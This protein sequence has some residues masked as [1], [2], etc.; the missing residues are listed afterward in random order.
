MQRTTVVAAFVAAVVFSI[1]GWLV[2]SQSHNVTPP[3]KPPSA[4]CKGNECTIE[5]LFDCAL[6]PC[7]PFPDRE[8]VLT[9]VKNAIKIKFQINDKK[10]EFNQSDGIKFTSSNS[11]GYF[12]C[13]PQGKQG[14]ECKTEKEIP[15]GVY[16][17]SIHVEGLSVVDPWVVNY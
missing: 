16:K 5:I 14:Y 17:Y 10:Y 3:S 13:T 7:V 6:T 1:V 12:L 8:V 9:S 4:E 2:G 15:G 11:N